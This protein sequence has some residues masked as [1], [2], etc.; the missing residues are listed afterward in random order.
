MNDRDLKKAILHHLAQEGASL[1]GDPWQAVQRRLLARQVEQQQTSILTRRRYQLVGLAAV[2]VLLIV[3]ATFLSTP[4]GQATAESILQFFVKAEKNTLPLPSEVPTAGILPTRTTGPV[5]ANAFTPTPWPRLESGDWLSGLTLAEAEALAQFKIVVPASLPP[6]YSLAVVSLN[7]RTNQVEQLYESSLDAQ[8]FVS[9]GAFI[10]SQSPK[11]EP[12]LVGPSSAI[13]QLVINETTVEWTH[14]GWFIPAGADH[15]EWDQAAP[16]YTYRWKQDDFYF[17]LTF[18]TNGTVD[19]KYLS[20]DNMQAL[21]EIIM[22]VRSIFP[23]IPSLSK[24]PGMAEAEQASGIQFIRPLQTPIGFAFQQAVYDSSAQGI[25][26]IYQPIEGPRVPTAAS[27]VIFEAP[28]A[29]YQFQ[30]WQGFPAGSIEQV[31]CKDYFGDTACIYIHGSVVDGKYVPTDGATLIFAQQG[32]L[33]TIE[34]KN[35]PTDPVELDKSAMI[36]L[37]YS[38]Q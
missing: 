13:N 33:I 36:N 11:L 2:A 14:G 5:I 23:W 29:N 6:D 30:T 1:E 20:Q 7:R 38:M 22:G 8:G 10:L 37:A 31:S 25:R 17:T 26:L 35:S 4:Q 12:Q 32:L 18:I 24:L 34:F 15:Q 16:T 9:K 19:P 3:S 21:V 27:L 28:E